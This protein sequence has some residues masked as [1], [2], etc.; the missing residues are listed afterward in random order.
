MHAKSAI[1]NSGVNA[2]M[3]N[4]LFEGPACKTGMRVSVWTAIA[5]ATNITVANCYIVSSSD[6]PKTRLYAR[7]VI[8]S[9]C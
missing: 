7:F 3:R 6:A 4:E 8:E 2:C 9:S 5:L 1:V